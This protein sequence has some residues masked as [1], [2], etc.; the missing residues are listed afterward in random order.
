MGGERMGIQ[1]KIQCKPNMLCLLSLFCLSTFLVTVQYMDPSPY[2]S[3]LFTAIGIYGK[4]YVLYYLSSFSWQ[5]N[6]L[7]QGLTPQEA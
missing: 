2:L 1:P 5:A 3:D 7:L 4:G 6:Q